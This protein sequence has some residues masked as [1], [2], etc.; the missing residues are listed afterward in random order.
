MTNTKF[1]EEIQDLKTKYRLKV[2]ELREVES[3][4]RKY[5]LEISNQQNQIVTKIDFK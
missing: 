3:M 5:E 2:K 1:I 4:V